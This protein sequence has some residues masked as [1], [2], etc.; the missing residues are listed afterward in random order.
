M[1]GQLGPAACHRQCIKWQGAL[2][3][4]HIAHW[5][6][7]RTPVHCH[8]PAAN[9]QSLASCIHAAASTTYVAGRT[10]FVN[11]PPK[12]AQCLSLPGTG[13]VLLLCTFLCDLRGKVLSI[14]WSL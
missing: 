14:S 2:V 7:I 6:A 10:L 12:H 9:M 11:P 8:C 3:H 13:G 1:V 5:L 4:V